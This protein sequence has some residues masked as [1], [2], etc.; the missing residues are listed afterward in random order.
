MRRHFYYALALLPTVC[1][2][3]RVLTV[4]DRLANAAVH[5]NQLGLRSATYTENGMWAP[6]EFALESPSPTDAWAIV[7]I[8]GEAIV[9][10]AAREFANKAATSETAALV[11]AGVGE[12]GTAWLEL[13]RSGAALVAV[14][15]EEL[16]L[17]EGWISEESQALAAPYTPNLRARAERLGE[18]LGSAERI[19][20]TRGAS[21]SA[22]A[23]LWCNGGTRPNGMK[24]PDPF[25]EH[26]GMESAP[27]DDASADGVPEA[28]LAALLTA[29]LVDKVPPPK[30]LERA[31]ALGSYVASTSSAVPRHDDAPEALCALF[32]REAA[33]EPPKPAAYG[34]EAERR[35]AAMEA[36]DAA[37]G[38]SDADD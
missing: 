1:V 21:A 29:L 32:R 37:D 6:R 24:K 27:S 3:I 7:A 30:A 34:G 38:E 2:S 15:E 13:A 28:F 18:A 9:D 35:R 36:M 12:D 26:A 23:S 11:V 10:D 17:I 16:S 14:S 25:F 33:Q 31:C 22:G 5:L 19:C 20:V 8:D 4:G